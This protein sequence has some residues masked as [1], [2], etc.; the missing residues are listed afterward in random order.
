MPGL[1]W[2]G[3]T[4]SYIKNE[5]VEFMQT[6]SHWLLTAV[7]HKRLQHYQKIEKQALLVGSTAPDVP[8]TVISIG[9][10]LDRRLI[11]RHLPDKTRCSPTYNDLYF[12]N[13]WWIAAYNLFHAP[14]PVLVLGMIG[15]VAQRQRWGRW[16]LW[17]AI[18]CALH[19]AVDIV[20]HADD[21]PLL[22]FPLEWYNKRF[23]SPISYWDPR[24]GG[25]IFQL[26]EH[27]LDFALAAYLIRQKQ[28]G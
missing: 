24:Y 5:C 7:I 16:L 9:Y 2:P 17:F 13:A 1:T 8:L 15:Y 18:G 23:L 25:R 12:N 6:Y 22:L 14:L 27:L 26:V 4:K 3:S 10:L 20:T 28:G 19:T 11:R 21:G